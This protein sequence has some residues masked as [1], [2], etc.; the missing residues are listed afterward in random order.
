MDHVDSLPVSSH[1]A[2]FPPAN[3]DDNDGEVDADKSD[4]DDKVGSL[5]RE[6]FGCFNCHRAVFCYRSTLEVAAEI[7]IRDFFLVLLPVLWSADQKALHR[8]SDL[9]KAPY[10]AALRKEDCFHS[11]FEAVSKKDPDLMKLAEHAA[12]ASGAAVHALL[13]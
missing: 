3:D 9:E 2:A 1:S 7:P 8:W 12:K 11:S 6:D 13:V 5:I 4:T 10:F